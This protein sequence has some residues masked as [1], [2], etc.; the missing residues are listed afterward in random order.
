MY[1]SQPPTMWQS[2]VSKFREL[3]T[4]S[5]SGRGRNY[6]K[7]CQFRPRFGACMYLTFILGLMEVHRSLQHR[8]DRTEIIYV[9]Q[10]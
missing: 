2:A 4:S 5:N 9:S 1:S 10:D 3:V 7:S 6:W 8:Q